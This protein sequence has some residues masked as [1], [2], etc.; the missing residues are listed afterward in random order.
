MR[1][2]LIITSTADRNA[3]IGRLSGALIDSLKQKNVDVDVMTCNASPPA[4]QIIKESLSARRRASQAEI[5]HAFD[6]WPWGIYA[7]FA[8]IGTKKKLFLSGIGT[9]SISPFYYLLRRVLAKTVYRRAQEVFCIS[10]YTCNRIREHMPVLR[11]LSVVHLG[12]TGFQRVEKKEIEDVRQKFE[13]VGKGPIIFTAGDVKH[14][15]GQFDTLRAVIRL[16]E[17]YPD[18]AYVLAGSTNNKTYVEQMKQYAQENDFETSLIFAGKVVNDQ[19][20]G[21]FYGLADVFAMNSNNEGKYEEHIEGFGLVF[22]EA[23][24]MGLPVVGSRNCGIEDAI[25]DGYNGYLTNQGDDQDIARA[26]DRV[27]NGNREQLARNSREFA[28]RFS[29]EKS[30]EAYIQAYIR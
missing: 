1:K 9:Y 21:A 16:K 22:L 18:I 11:N 5:V 30:A 17:K 19:M 13:L 28:K 29:W 26:I 24:S 4:L 27:L 8:V 10:T 6:V 3:G 12:T 2:V 20:L 25:E 7:W 15:K 23:A 14:R